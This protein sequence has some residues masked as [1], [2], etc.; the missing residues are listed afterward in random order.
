VFAFTP[1]WN[2][3]IAENCIGPDDEKVRPPVPYN[4]HPES[5]KTIAGFP[6]E[7]AKRAKAKA[8]RDARQS[9]ENQVEAKNIML[10][11]Q[12]VQKK[13][14]RASKGSKSRRS[15]SPRASRKKTIPENQRR[16]FPAHL[17]SHLMMMVMKFPCMINVPSS[18]SRTAAPHQ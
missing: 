10:T 6:D 12:D 8:K 4:A 15:V 9:K 16:L 7:V 18:T 2:D 3:C 17:M 1:P 11:Q 5:L 13:K 14:D